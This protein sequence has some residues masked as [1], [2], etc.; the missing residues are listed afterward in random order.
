MSDRRPTVRRP[1]VVFHIGAPKT[2]TTYLQ[3]ILWQNRAALRRDDVLYPGDRSTAH[4]WASLDLRGASFRGHRDSGVPGAWRRL[5]DEVRAWKGTAVIDHESFSSATQRHIDQAVTDLAFADLHVVCT[6]RDMARQLP[7][8][9]QERVKNGASLTFADFLATVQSRNRRGGPAGRFW[10]AQDVPAVLARWSRHVG[11]ERVHVV[12]VPP[13]GSDQGELWR[14]F[15]GLLG[16]EPHRYDSDVTEPNTSMGATEAAVL[17]RLNAQIADS[18]VAWPVYRRVV[19]HHVA[20]LL[21]SREGTPVAL[22]ADAYAWTVAWAERAVQKMTDAG[23]HVVGDLRELVP[24]APPSG[25]DPDAAP[26]DEQA[27]AAVAGMAALL[28]LRESRT[29]PGG[30]S[31]TGT[32]EHRRRLAEFAYDQA[33]SVAGRVRWIGTLSRRRRRRAATRRR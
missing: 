11:A 5:V 4:F 18:P 33:R 30:V 19:K 10:R 15:A 7:A 25:L 9:W 16:V 2:G 28:S 31:A 12:T 8:V 14:R 23:Y 24:C 6:A 27:E 29:D 32:S 13:P 22:S 20:P 26:P 17:R 21:A 1:T 3:E